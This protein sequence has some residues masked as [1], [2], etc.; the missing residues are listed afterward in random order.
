MPT[1]L[2]VLPSDK[3]ITNGRCQIK[4]GASDVAINYNNTVPSGKLQDG[5]G[6]W[7]EIFYTPTYACYWVV[8][9]NL[10]THGLDGDW[11]RCDFG[12][13]ITPADA[14]G[15]TLGYQACMQTYPYTTVE[16][17][18]WAASYMFKLNP[19]V[20]YTAYLAWWYSSGYTQ[21][22]HFGPRWLR[23]TGRIVS[24]GVL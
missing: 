5:A 8:R 15:T 7:M 13:C 4:R 3:P 20:A 2:A 14:E 12:V 10:M 19:G 18:T 1:N 21:Q 17:R 22:I 16:W 23:I 9:G 24:E 11:R 6:G